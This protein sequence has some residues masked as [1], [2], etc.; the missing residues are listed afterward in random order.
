VRDVR[1]TAALRSE[2]LTVATTRG[3]DVRRSCR[4]D[5]RWVEQE[6]PPRTSGA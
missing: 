6:L 5:V 2:V 1:E 3:G 4:I